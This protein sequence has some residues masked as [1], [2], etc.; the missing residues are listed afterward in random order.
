MAQYMYCRVSSADQRDT[1]ASLTAQIERGLSLGIPRENIF[2]DGGKSGGVHE[3][4][5]EYEFREGRFLIIKID[6][7]PRTE[8]RKLLSLLKTSDEIFFVRMAGL[9]GWGI[10]GEYQLSRDS[11]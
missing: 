9:I 8:F 4:E 11:P 5:L 10:C 3:E 1:G 7:Q 6:L 2:A